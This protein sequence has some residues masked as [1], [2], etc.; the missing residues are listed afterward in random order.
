MERGQNIKINRSL[1]EAEPTLKD[2]SEGFWT[3]AER[4]AVVTECE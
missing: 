2:S 4:G 1:E 3:S